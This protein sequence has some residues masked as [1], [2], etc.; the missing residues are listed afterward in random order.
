MA[1]DDDEYVP[2]LEEEDSE[3]ETSGREAMDVEDYATAVQRDEEDY[4][5]GLTTGVQCCCMR[6]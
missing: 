4:L 1:D 3:N 5:R 2:L 6:E